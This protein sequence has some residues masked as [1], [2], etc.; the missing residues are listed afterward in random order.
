MSFFGRFTPKQRLWGAIGGVIV[1]GS[2]F[3][4]A[5]F[6]FCR[7]MLVENAAKTHMD[8]TASLHEARQFAEWSSRQ[9]EQERANLPELT[10]EQDK[11]LK[12]YLR[13][14]QEYHAFN[15]DSDIPQQ[16]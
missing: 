2:A 6:K 8:A 15:P 11:Q 3:K 5:Y 14:M 9:R 10:K 7:E 13:M 16:K 12:A 1:A 4:V